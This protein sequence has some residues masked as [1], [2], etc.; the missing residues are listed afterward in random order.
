MPEDIILEMKEIEIAFPGVKALDKVDFTLR[1]GEVHSLLGE[2]GA[3]KST[4]MNI[5]NGVFPPS[6]GYV[7]LDGEKLALTSPLDALRYGIGMVYQ[8]FMLVDELRVWQNIVLGMEE[9][10]PLR[11]LDE[12]KMKARI[13]AAC[14]EYN[15]EFVIYNF[16]SNTLFHWLTA[17][18]NP[19]VAKIG[20]ERGNTILKKHVMYP[21]PSISADSSNDAGIASIEV[22]TKIILY[23][24][25][26]C[27]TI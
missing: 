4:L 27:G 15:F 17:E 2:N 20:F 1:K 11:I 24:V 23:T 22:L 9:T 10:G 6:G 25:N 19:T 16:V 7:T 14:K 8:H 26:K 13:E 18:N 12:K 5:L 21:A 3:G